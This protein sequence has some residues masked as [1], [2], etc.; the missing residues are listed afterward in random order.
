MTHALAVRLCNWIGDV[1]L[2]LPALRLLEDHGHALHLYGKGWAPTL[3]T[4]YDWPVLTRAKVLKERVAQLATLKR[5]LAASDPALDAH[6]NALAMPN[7]FSSA[8]ELRLAG[9]KVAGYA[10]DG[11]SLL[12][13]QRHRPGSAPH[14]LQSFWQLAC[15]ML[16]IDRP[17]P[18]SIGM[19]LAPA[20]VERARGLVQ[21]RG[22]RDGHVCVAP[23]AAGTV[24]KLPKKWP[25]FPDFV[26]A[27]AREGLPI[28]ICPGPGELDEARTL[29]PGAQIVEDLPLDAYAALL[30]EARLVVA[31][32]TGPGHLAAGVGAPLVSVLGPTKVEQWAPWGPSVSVLSARPDFPPLDTVLAVARQRLAG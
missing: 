26:R 4:G 10:R 30:K 8:L 13:K 3:L 20:A 1:V 19:R 31:N 28:V 24:H 14:A 16:G 17:P 22:W 11:R 5:T 32:D 9:F 7:S 18:A 21:A 23:F 27:F 15:G 6:V 12:L 29:Y 25:A 2:S